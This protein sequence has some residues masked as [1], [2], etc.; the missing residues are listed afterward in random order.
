MLSVIRINLCAHRHIPSYF[1]VVSC[2]ELYITLFVC[3]YADIIIGYIMLLVVTVQLIC[4]LICM[5]H[6]IF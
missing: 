1:Q 3:Y 2:M 6:H 4:L 5:Y